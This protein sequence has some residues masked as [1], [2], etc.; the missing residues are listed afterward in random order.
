MDYLAQ[1]HKYYK[2]FY[3]NNISVDILKV[4]SDFS[5]YKILVAP[6]LYMEKEETAD[7]IK[8]FTKN[9][10]IFIATYMTGLVDEND[11]CVF[12]AYPGRY[13]DLLGIRVEETDA[14]FPEERNTLLATEKLFGEKRKYECGFLCDLIYLE[15]AETLAVYEK[16][17]YKGFP[18]VTV[19]RFGKG[20]A[21]Y[22]AS[23]P[24]EEFLR[25]FIQIIFED[26]NIKPIFKAKKNVE[27]TRR[28]NKTG[29]IIFIIN[30]NEQ[31]SIVELGD[32]TFINLLNDK[33]ITGR[34]EI[35]ASNV[36]VKKKKAN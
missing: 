35:D 33:H 7:R 2:V 17:F 27:I 34:Y 30:H 24:E 14:L 15:D 1:V 28:I 16:N 36:L 25:D 32:E 6:L 13:R 8:E 21:F 29:T 26:H 19:N 22:I 11:R 20:K 5:K 31:K 12:G 3:D 23:D 4:T 10:G 18:C 9:G